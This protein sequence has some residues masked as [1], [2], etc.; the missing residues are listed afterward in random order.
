MSKN[1]STDPDN[2]I[3][4]TYQVIEP[5]A[6][7]ATATVYRGHDLSRDRPVAIK[8]AKEEQLKCKDNGELY[9]KIFVNEARAA[10]F[11]EH[12]NIVAIFDIAREDDLHY[13]VMEYVPGRQ[14]VQDYCSVENLLSLREIIAILC[15]C[16]TALDYAHKQGVIHRDIK[17]RN[18]LLTDGKDVK[19]SDFGIA[20]FP[21]EPDE[22]ILGLAGSPLYMSP[23]GVEGQELTPQSDLFSLG[24]VMYEMITGKHPFRGTNMSAIGHRI[25]HTRAQQLGQFRV[26]VPDVLERIVER[27]LAKSPMKRY[28]SG[29]DLAGDLSLVLDFLEGDEDH[30]PNQEKFGL[31]KENEF[32]RAFPDTELW[33]LISASAWR[34]VSRGKE[35]VLNEGVDKSFYI[36]ISG[37]VTVTKGHNRPRILK[38]GDCFGEIGSSAKK[39]RSSTIRA[40]DD[41]T[42]MKVHPP[43]I[44]R[45]SVSCQL[46]FHKLFLHNLVD[47]LSGP[48]PPVLRSKVTKIDFLIDN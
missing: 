34:H 13:I 14:T 30:L 48:N 2:P 29:M 46:R 27:A 1:L 25:T 20:V 3:F 15:Q 45:A 28:R 41:V 12:P 26:D 10:A 24:V 44:A 40:K 11:L 37:S 33:E 6:T 9:K 4:S 18:I 47:R 32:F 21:G 43:M 7:G 39:Q 36:I 35:V 17:P 23:E 5:I 22:Q 16:A 38:P 8:V 19:I 42:I 31:I